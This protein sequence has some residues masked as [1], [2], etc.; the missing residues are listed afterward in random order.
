MS[1]YW[2]IDTLNRDPGGNLYSVTKRMSTKEID[3]G[4]RH[5]HLHGLLIDLFM[6]SV[7]VGDVVTIDH[8]PYLYFVPR[9]RGTREWS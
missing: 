5:G 1:T 3:L 2:N 9:L 7:N 4:K 8:V 6:S